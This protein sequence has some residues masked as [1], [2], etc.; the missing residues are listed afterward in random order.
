M[1]KV[2]FLIVR[3][4]SIGD[5]VLTTPVIRCL[6]E[7]VPNAEIHYLTKKQFV[8]LL[9][10]NPAVD[11]IWPFDNNLNQILNEIKYQHPDYIIDL[12]NNLRSRQVKSK[13]KMISFTF[14]KINFEKW[15]M[16]NFKRNKLPDRHIV[17]RY[18][19]TIK[20]FD[21]KN[22]LKGL[23]YFLSDSDKNLPDDIMG[24]LPDEFIAVAI[25]ANHN[26]K[27]LPPAKF[28]EII[29]GLDLPVVILGGPTDTEAASQILANVNKNVID[30]T[31]KVSLN[32]SAF[33]LQIS[34]LVITHDTGM[35]HIA[36]A[37]GKK[38]L[39]IWGNTIPEFGMY[40]YMPHP[41]SEIFEIQGLKCRP[42][43][44]IGFQKCPKK[45]FNCMM[46]QDTKEIARHANFISHSSH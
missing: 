8:P 32:Q 23:D 14:N 15:L 26:T 1:Q 18:M 19:D 34:K 44:K 27:K 11:K 38:I 3:F 24:I 2:K 20:A 40:P 28:S 21:V 6:K 25:G 10:N 45:H 17:D 46:L 4:S 43:S 5:I 33:L 39:S 31:G 16:V 37:F 41:D 36:S 13:L 29:A 7:Q 22:D 35:M 42:C 30:T 9:Q 12:H